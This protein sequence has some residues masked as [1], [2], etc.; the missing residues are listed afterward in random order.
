MLKKSLQEQKRFN[1]QL[2]V[3][4]LPAPPVGKTGWPWDTASEW[5]DNIIPKV[6][7]PKISI[8]TPSYNQGDYL[9]ATIRSVLLQNYPNL[10]Y[11]II[12]G[13]STDE[14]LNI[15]KKYEPW[16]TYWSSEK[17]AGQADAVNKGLA[18][19]SGDI[20]GWINSDDYYEGNA[21][22]R[23]SEEYEQIQ[24]GCLIAG[25][26]RRVDE[27]E[28]DL[29]SW[30][31]RTPKIYPLLYHYQLHRFRELSAI[32]CQPS[33]FFSRDMYKDIGTL[34]PELHYALDYEYWLRAIFHGYQFKQIPEILSNY[35]FH[36]AS[37]NPINWTNCYSEWRKTA[38]TYFRQ[39]SPLKKMLGSLYY[40]FVLL[41][42]KYTLTL[43]VHFKKQILC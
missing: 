11:I 6:D 18:Q 10:E 39:L 7:Y 41:P 19:A 38:E 36:D 13:G 32:P 4:K 17:D 28:N 24:S 33:V 3:E 15:I 43:L 12:D 20:I 27:S 42:A 34:R 25:N 14:S 9:E 5:T 35:R 40:G 37:K 30:V 1:M 23:I 2:I 21:L 29:G 16:I 22:L 26:Y 8:I 31:I